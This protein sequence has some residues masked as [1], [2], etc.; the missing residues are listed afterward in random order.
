MPFAHTICSVIGLTT[1]IGT[2]T[3]AMASARTDGDDTPVASAESFEAEMGPNVGR[4]PQPRRLSPPEPAEAIEAEPSRLHLSLGVDYATAYFSRGFRYEDSGWIIQP[5]ADLA[6]DVYRRD[7]ATISLTVGTWNSFHGLATDAGTTDSFKQYWYENDLYAGV[8]L[9]A[10]EWSIEAR[11]YSYASPSD[12]WETIEELYFSAAFDDSGL[13][14][15]WSL[16][17]SAILAIETGDVAADGGE[18]GTYFQFGVSPGVT[19]EQGPLSDFTLSF[20]VTVGVS[21]SDYFEGA[22]GENDTFGYTS[23]GA[24]LDVP[25]NTGAAWGGWT[26][27]VGVQGVFLGDAASTLNNDD[28]FDI[29]GTA[30]VSAEF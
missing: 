1:V 16:Q 4:Q 20:P 23:V 17:P 14:G 30:G 11:Y 26:L 22:N 15:S 8:S 19:F 21:L 27:S 9:E 13:L 28:T 2:A 25:L 6:V 12:A 10:G 29:V 7:D 3:A 24:T 18:T 5:Y